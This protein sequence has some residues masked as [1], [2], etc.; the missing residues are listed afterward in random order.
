MSL[1]IL[2]T[3][4]L[5]LYEKNHPVVIARVS[6][7]PPAERA[8]T[9]LTVEEQLS[10]WYTR[11]RQAKRPDQLAEAYR[12]LAKTIRFFA[13][14][15]IIDYDEPTIARYERLRKQNVKIG[16]NDLRIAAAVLEQDAVLVTRNV[17]DFRQV[18]GLS[19][20]D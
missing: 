17:R 3:D 7:H 12:R 15:Q 1:Y 20:E 5:T 9:V 6:A 10:G 4:M 18:P 13:R 11:I 19:I 16:R 2:D 14:L 8:I